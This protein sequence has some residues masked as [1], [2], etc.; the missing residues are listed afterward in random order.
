[1]AISL[2]CPTA[3]GRTAR[4]E[5]GYDG[6]TDARSPPPAPCALHASARRVF[7]ARGDAEESHALGPQRPGSPR[8]G[9]PD[10]VPGPV[11]GALSAGAPRSP[12]R[13]GGE[14]DGGGDG[15]EERLAGLPLR[16]GGGP[17][18]GAAGRGDLAGSPP[19][20]SSPRKT[21]K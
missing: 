20:V 14:P 18:H 8:G 19:R 3:M 11:S 10:G 21:P 7:D 5:P 16:G 9:V 15:V 4:T 17:S 12:P 13:A 2:R 6:S 1:M